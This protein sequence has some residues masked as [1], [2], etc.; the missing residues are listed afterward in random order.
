MKFVAGDEGERYTPIRKPFG[1]ELVGNRLY[2]CDAEGGLH[3]IDLEN[4]TFE[5]WGLREP[6]N[7]VRPINAAVDGDDGFVYVADMGRRQV[8]V[9]D[10]NGEYVRSYGKTGDFGGPVDVELHD[11]K[12]Y[13]CDVKKHTVH[14]VDVE[15]GEVV[16]TIGSPGSGN[17]NLFHP[18]NICIRNDILYVSDTTNFRVQMFRLNGKPLDR[19]GA[20]GTRPGSFARPKG[21]AVDREGRVY[22]AD[23]AFENI[24]VF[25]EQHRLLL[26]FL[27]AGNAP[28]MINLPDGISISYD[29]PQRLR[30][31]VVPGF[32]AEYLLLV[33]SQYGLNKINIY[34]FGKYRK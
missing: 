9:F 13:V 17:S 30:D 21:I 14:V 31:L 4:R 27:R 33:N 19:F 29:I 16:R 23:A 1:S 6:G 26:Y 12:L 24:Q 15:S 7:L 22:V 28:G 10:R 32:E 5:T 18:T 2:V 25:D 8:V 20:V 3:I 34:A 11:G